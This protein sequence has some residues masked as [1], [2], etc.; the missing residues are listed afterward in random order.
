MYVL[1]VGLQ[2]NSKP[3]LF[4]VKLTWNTSSGQDSLATDLTNEIFNHP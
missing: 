4:L 3:A 2:L 1:H